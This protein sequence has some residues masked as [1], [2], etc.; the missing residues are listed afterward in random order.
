MK[1][2]KEKDISGSDFVMLCLKVCLIEQKHMISVLVIKSVPERNTSLL[3]FSA[4]TE[5][6]FILNLVGI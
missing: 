3:H 5:C 6:S 4:Q 1:D 2:W